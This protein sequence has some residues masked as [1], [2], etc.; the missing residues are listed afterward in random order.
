MEATKISIPRH[1]QNEASGKSIPSEEHQESAHLAAIAQLF[2][3]E[4]LII[5]PIIVPTFKTLNN[6]SF[7]R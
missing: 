7:P 4:A 3:T 2:S 5:C 1:R 6:Q